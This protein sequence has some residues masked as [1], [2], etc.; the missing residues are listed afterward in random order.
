MNELQNCFILSLAQAHLVYLL[1]NSSLSVKLQ[2]KIKPPPLV[3][4]LLSCPVC[5]GFWIA[6]LFALGHPIETLAI[7]FLG[8][9]F[10]ELR[11]KFLPCKECTNNTRLS[12][13]K[14]S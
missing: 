6:L 7:G 10:Y 11:Q 1:V 8:G 12:E 2:S 13:W 5:I 14:V 9:C 4:Q 3:K